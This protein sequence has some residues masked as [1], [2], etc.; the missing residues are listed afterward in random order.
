M[1]V[2][3]RL[4]ACEVA[5]HRA[6]GGVV[7]VFGPLVALSAGRDVPLNSAWLDG[8]RPP[9]K[10]ELQEFEDFCAEQGQAAVVQVLSHAAPKVIPV[11]R[12]AGYALDYVL[13]AYAHD[14]VDVPSPSPLPVQPEVDALEW[15]RVS[16][17]GFGPDSEA[18]MRLVAQH[19]HVQRFSAWVGNEVAGTAAMQLQAGVA[20]LYG[21]STRPEYRRQGVQTAL[22][23]HRLHEARRQGATLASVFVTPGTPS[24]RNITRA[25]FRLAGVRLTFGKERSKCQNV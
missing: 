5:S 19:P 21:T 25:G 20:A 24:E 10:A 2:L 13:H 3:E 11:L 9:T 23:L 8:S 16:A 17:L 22:L 15:A 4:N 12:E 18:I 7:G 6:G 1:T 14:L